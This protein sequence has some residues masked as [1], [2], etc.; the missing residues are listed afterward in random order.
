MTKKSTVVGKC[1][2]SQELLIQV[3]E[4]GIAEMVLNCKTNENELFNDSNYT[5]AISRSGGGF[6]DNKYHCTNKCNGNT[7]LAQAYRVDMKIHGL[8]KKTKESCQSDCR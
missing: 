4:K 2:A 7:C 1:A 5:G 8:D 3:E 6:K